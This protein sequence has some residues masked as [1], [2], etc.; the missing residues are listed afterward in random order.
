MMI[1][2]HTY[3]QCIRIYFQK[4]CTICL[5]RFPHVS[6][7]S[8]LWLF[9]LLF[10]TP[11]AHLLPELSSQSK[12]GWWFMTSQSMTGIVLPMMASFFLRKQGPVEGSMHTSVVAA[13]NT[14][15]MVPEADVTG[16]HGVI[17][18]RLSLPHHSGGSSWQRPGFPSFQWKDWTSQWC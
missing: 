1:K 2:T 15:R 11:Q 6:D 7:K 17:S 4:Y 10:P 9:T 12:W 14:E 3:I 13:D 18:W 16:C 8:M 5:W